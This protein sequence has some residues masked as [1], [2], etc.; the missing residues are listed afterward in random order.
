VPLLLLP[1]QLLCVRLL[2]AAQLFSALLE[3]PVAS[4]ALAFAPFVEWLPTC[5]FL[6]P[7]V[8]LRALSLLFLAGPV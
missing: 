1:P 2:P 6:A 3:L 8:L 7:A 5:L 4:L